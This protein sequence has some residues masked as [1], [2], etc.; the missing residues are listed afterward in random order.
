MNET[1]IPIKCVSLSYPTGHSKTIHDN[2]VIVLDCMD[3]VLIKLTVETLLG[4]LYK[5]L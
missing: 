4:W 5:V 2:T 1:N 3:F